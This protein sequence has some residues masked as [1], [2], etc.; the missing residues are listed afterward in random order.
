MGCCLVKEQMKDKHIWNLGLFAQLLATLALSCYVSYMQ[1]YKYWN[2]TNR[3]VRI[4]CCY[5]VLGS[6][7]QLQAACSH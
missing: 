4:Q 3:Y 2:R 1:I 5:L 6:R 7:Q